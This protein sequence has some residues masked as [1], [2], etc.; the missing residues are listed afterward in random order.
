MDIPFD[1]IAIWLAA[2]ITI[3]SGIDYFVKN[4]NILSFSKI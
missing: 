2:L 3:Y 1:E 4:R